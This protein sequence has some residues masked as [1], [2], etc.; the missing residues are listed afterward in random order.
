VAQILIKL[1]MI[2]VYSTHCEGEICTLPLSAESGNY[3]HSVDGYCFRI[4]QEVFISPKT[5][6]SEVADLFRERVEAEVNFRSVDQGALETFATLMYVRVYDENGNFLGEH[7]GMFMTC[8][9]KPVIPI[10]VSLVRLSALD[11]S[12]RPHSF[13][14][15][16]LKS[17]QPLVP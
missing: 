6:A 5:T 2:L 17:S 12:G 4:N 10:G 15:L 8:V 13:L 14:W 11:P 9:E 7:G 3:A 1:L 16:V